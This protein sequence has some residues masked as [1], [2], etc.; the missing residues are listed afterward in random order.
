[1]N[2]PPPDQTWTSEPVA[3]IGAGIVGLSIA[4]ELAINRGHRVTL[5]DTGHPGRGA[6]WAA[7]GMI[8][9]AFEAAAEPG[10]HPHLF[11]LCMA[12]AALWPSFAAQ[13]EAS[14]GEPIGFESEASLAVALD[15][16]QHDHLSQIAGVLASRGVAHSFLDAA[17]LRRREPAL[18]GEVRGG[19]EL[20][21]DFRVQNRAVVSALEAVLRATP[22]VRFEDGAA[23]LR[24]Q[25]GRV[26]L[27]GHGA[28]VA[29]AGWATA[30]IKVEEHGQLHS[31]VNWDSAL[32][33]IN[34]F[35]GQM[36][37][38]KAGPGA[39]ERVV[40]AGHV[41]LVPRG[42]EVVIGATMEP[43][44]VID[45]P[46]PEIV[47]GLRQEGIRI[48][49]GLAGAPVVESWAGVR[50]GTPDHAPFLGRT[51]VPGLF[52]AAGHYRN[53]ILLA[54]STAQILADELEGKTTGELASAF[55]TNRAFAATD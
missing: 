41:Y 34:C 31:L 33:E 55:S 30:A 48:C 11:D 26:V 5:F 42:G 10:V 27:D 35:G 37:S 6:S 32:D 20:P 22:G 17:E 47:E 13:L 39:P 29:A 54:P 28:V 12:S 24:A 53:G 40:R 21:T 16:A 8:A 15:A 43:G 50:P 52:V 14:S 23:P 25:G 44:R 1:M 9:P 2:L 45:T 3:I 4:F 19:M 51:S 38:V 18:A 46:E 7:A 36:L 49:P